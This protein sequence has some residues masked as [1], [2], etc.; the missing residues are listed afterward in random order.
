[1]MNS[2]D[3]RVER[4]SQQPQSKKDIYL[5][6][7]PLQTREMA[8]YCREKSNIKNFPSP[9]GQE[10]LLQNKDG[11]HFTTDLSFSLKSAGWEIL[12]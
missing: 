2:I 5:Q 12:K 6:R 7:E 8:T 3:L 1:M 9:K 11:V 4:N 10:K